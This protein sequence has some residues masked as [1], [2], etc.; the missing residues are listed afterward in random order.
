MGRSAELTGR[1]KWDCKLYS[2]DTP[3]LIEGVDNGFVVFNYQGKQGIEIRKAIQ[4]EDVQWVMQRLGKL[5]DAQID[6]ALRASGA[7]PDEVACFGKAF[8]SRLNQ[9]RMVAG[10]KLS[11]DAATTRTRREIRTTVPKPA[12]D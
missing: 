11:D 6:G 2:A 1:S 7:T 8:R 10:Q 5:S 4:V 12:Q 3:S 9:L